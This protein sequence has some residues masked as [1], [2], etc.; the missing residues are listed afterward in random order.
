MPQPDSDIVSLRLARE[1][2]TLNI[3]STHVFPIGLFK[4]SLDGISDELGLE[5]I[6]RDN[7]LETSSLVK[8]NYYPD[9]MSGESPL[10]TGPDLQ[11]KKELAPLCNTIVDVIFEIIKQHAIDPSYKID[12]T[13]LWGNLQPKGHQFHR[14]THHNNIF[15]G[16]LYVNEVNNLF[17]TERGKTFPHI[18]F[19]SPRKNDQLNLVKNHT[20]PLNR[21][22]F[23]VPVK[24][25]LMVIFPAW[26]EHEVPMNVTSEDRVSI[27]FNVMLRGQYGATGSKETSVF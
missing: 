11:H 14:H 25:D 8:M 5:K 15:G 7:I 20:H 6:V 26:L 21:Y 10:Q 22:S 19:W 1:E 17:A 18:L 3:E 9:G 16:V 13:G 27:A 2:A 23:N 12:I 24:K 4:T